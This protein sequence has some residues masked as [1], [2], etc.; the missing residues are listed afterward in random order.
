MGERERVKFVFCEGGCEAALLVCLPVRL[1]GH[2]DIGPCLQIAMLRLPIADQLELF[3]KLK[4]QA[5]LRKVHPFVLSEDF[6]LICKPRC[7][8]N[9]GG[10]NIKTGVILN[11]FS[12]Q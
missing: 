5:L 10:E 4:Q 11:G 6:S 7:I 8:P 12:R 1:L 2:V 9:R 3:P